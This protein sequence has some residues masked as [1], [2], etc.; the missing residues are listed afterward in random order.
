MRERK[1]EGGGGDRGRK[2]DRA[3]EK[4]KWEKAQCLNHVNWY[5]QMTQDLIVM[6]DGLDILLPK[7]Q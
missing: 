6:R 7:V 3:R 1:R 5:H 2:G 4:E